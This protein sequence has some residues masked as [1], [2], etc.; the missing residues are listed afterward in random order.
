MRHEKTGQKSG[1]FVP[2]QILFDPRRSVA[3]WQIGR[4][5]IEVIL[6]W[7]WRWGRGGCVYYRRLRCKR[8]YQLRPVYFATSASTFFRFSRSVSVIPAFL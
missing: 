5:I 7:F 1:F 6:N 3:Y 8:V 4:S 2:N